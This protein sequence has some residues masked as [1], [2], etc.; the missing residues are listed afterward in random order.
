ME[1]KEAVEIGETLLF[2][3]GDF[4][5]SFGCPARHRTPRQLAA[6]DVNW[7]TYVEVAGNPT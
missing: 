7:R 4:T 6:S 1:L 2:V 3:A 5:R